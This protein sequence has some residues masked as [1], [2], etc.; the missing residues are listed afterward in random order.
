MAVTIEEVARHAGVSRATVSRI[1]TN[2]PHVSEAMRARVMAA[3]EELGYQPSRIARSLRV[4]RSEIIALIISDIQNP[5]YTALVRAVEDAAYAERHAVFL[6]N[7]DED[8]EKEKLYIDLVLAERVAGV[9]IT[10]TRETGN[11]SRALLDASIPVVS[12]D[13]RMRDLDV[14]TV[15]I[16]NFA[17]AV[18]LTAH[19]I[20]NGHRRIGGIFGPLTITTSAERFRGY[21]EAMRAHGIPF[22]PELVR[23]GMPKEPFGYQSAEALL[24]LD[25]PPTALLTANN[26]LATG[27]L[28]AVFTRGLRVPDDIALAT[29]DDMQCFSQPPITVVSQPTYELGQ[30]AAALL[31]E[32]IA[33][34]SRPTREV[35]LESKLIIRGSSGPHREPEGQSL[36]L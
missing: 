25:D 8:I 17:A 31:L 12:V 10:P 13:R 19:L 32:R 11:P 18:E 35:I 28:N 7:A 22:V 33:D 2:K 16:D 6:C 24:D 30:T 20:S 23:T 21:R 29:F 9:I 14:D 5:F 36:A 3:I 1:L 34:P 27:V 4:Q 26:L 15:V